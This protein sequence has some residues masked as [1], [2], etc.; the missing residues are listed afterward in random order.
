[1]TEHRRSG[2]QPSVSSASS[3]DAVS[4][5]DRREFIHTLGA[6]IALG[7]SRAY[8]QAMTEFDYIVIGAGSAGCVVANRLTADPNTRVLLLEAGGPPTADPSIVTPGRWV[9][10]LGTSVDWG[11]ATEA[12]AGLGGRVLAFPRGRIA[13][14]S[15]AIN[16][17]TYI[18]G[19]RLD[20]DGWRR[21]GLAG[22]GYD[23]VLPVFR[24][25]EDNSRG[26][27]EYR[28]AG[29]PLRVADGADPHAGH[30]AFLEAARS[31]GFRADPSWDFLLP[32][33]ENGAGYYQKNIKDGR[34]HSAADAFLSPVMG[35]PNLQV[36]TGAQAARLLV[37]KSRVTGVEFVREGQTRQ[38]RAAREVILSAGVIDSPKLLMLSG[39]GPADHLRAV[40]IPVVADLSGVG[41]NLQDHLKLSIRWQ[42][43]TTLPPSTV[44]AGLFVRSRSGGD[45]ASHAPDLQFYVGR[46]LDQPDRF[47]T[48]TVSLVRPA[49][50][51][52]VRLRSANP[53]DKPV[54]RGNYLAEAQDVTALLEGLRLARTLGRSAAYDSLRAEEI[55]PGASVVAEPALTEFVR[56]AVDTIYHPAGTCRMGTDSGAVVD[57]SLRVRGL[58]GLRIAD[59]SVMPDV[60]SATTHAACVMI[61]ARVAELVR[62]S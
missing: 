52:T 54:I 19:H 47:V 21:L 38:V 60:V 15:S 26:A 13:G 29:G 33:H 56:R 46:G 20:F 8:A 41:G 49:S 25:N 36:Y 22:W 3:A 14:G 53:A 44:T 30:A 50:R 57:A 17:M 35:R 62:Q 10:L 40:G 37:E 51:G 31:N 4:S 6:A 28:G 9:T 7:S 32:Q 16:A 11:Y 23:E 45:A 1:M 39:I 5:V 34:R 18:R 43:R 24:S 42:G 58:Q 48:I 27:S 61:G 12:E 55:E 2:P 59:A